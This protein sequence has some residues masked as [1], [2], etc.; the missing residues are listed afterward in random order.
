MVLRHFH[1]VAC[2][3]HSDQRKT[4]LYSPGVHHLCHI[5]GWFCELE[6]QWQCGEWDVINIQQQFLMHGEG[7]TCEKLFH[8][9]SF[10]V[11]LPL[12]FVRYA[13]TPFLN[14]SSLIVAFSMSKRE[15]PWVRTWQ[16]KGQCSFRVGGLEDTRRNVFRMWNLL[17]GHRVKH[18]FHFL[19]SS[20]F[21]RHRMG[22]IH[23]VGG[24]GSESYTQELE[25]LKRSK[26][27]QNEAGFRMLIENILK[28]EWCFEQINNISR[29][30]LN[31][32]TNP[33]S[34]GGKSL[35]WWETFHSNQYS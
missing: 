29:C 16:R 11:L 12:Y 10:S 15:A 35:F 28:V 9:S 7:C 24:E 4:F 32:C 6:Q 19:W 17:V 8:R 14:T 13:I 3:A 30:F 5:D 34:D 23:G 22:R 25:V 2:S 33:E 31:R 21:S 27:R 1:L 26:P 20:Y 18:L